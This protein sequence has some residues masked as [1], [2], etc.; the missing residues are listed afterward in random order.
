LNAYIEA[1]LPRRT[2]QQIPARRPDITT[3]FSTGKATTRGV[4]RLETTA[5]GLFHDLL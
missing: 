2:A 1:R 4:K 5:P 3:G